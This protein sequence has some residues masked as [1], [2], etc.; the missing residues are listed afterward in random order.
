MSIVELFVWKTTKTGIYMTRYLSTCY[1]LGF[2]WFIGLLSAPLS[3]QQ[4][5]PDFTQ[6]VERYGPAVVNIS[7]TAKKVDKKDNPIYRG[8]PGIPEDNP[9]HDFFRR[10]FDENNKLFEE[11]QPSTSLGSGFIISSDGYVVTNNHVIEDADEIIVRLTDRR[12]FTAELVGADK[13]SDVALLKVAADNLPTVE[14]GSSSSLKVGEWVLAIGSPFGFEHS[15]TAGI[16]SAK[17]RSLPSDTY[18]PFIQTDVAINPGNSGGPLFNLAGEV[19]GVNSQIYSRTGGFMGLSFAIPVDVMKNVVEQLKETGKVSRG[20]LG[21]LI[22]DVT[23]ELAQSFGMTKPQG[24]LIAKVLSDSPAAAADFKVGDII[25]TF[26]GKD[27]GRSADLPPLV[28]S[29]R[30]G[31]TVATTVMRQGE[32]KNLSV[33]I[34]ELPSDDE[35]QLAVTRQ[36]GKSATSTRLGL[37][38]IDLNDEKREKLGISEGGVLVQRVDEG[39][40]RDASISKGDV[41]MMIDNI[42]IRDVSHFK[43]ILSQLSAKTVPVLIHRRGSPLFLALKVPEK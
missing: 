43:E 28:G 33:T 3:A 25:I 8:I 15:V 32:T 31:S 38:V 18:V 24:A 29:T 1:V 9:L 13:R 36:G 17:G 41:I 10:F 20:W 42:D 23:Q 21:V 26:D 30:V 40:A 19:I 12:E 6:M 5:L 39:P 35:I 2:C 34:G 11:G 4:Q 22:Q 7:T 16:V 14:L 37:L 27:I